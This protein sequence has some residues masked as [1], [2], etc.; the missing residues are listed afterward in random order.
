MGG[1][2]SIFI[3]HTPGDVKFNQDLMESVVGDWYVEVKGKEHHFRVNYANAF[4][5]P[6]G[7]LMNV[8]LTE[9]SQH[10]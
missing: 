1:E 2:V 9:D 4:D 6:V 10:Y 5:K 3:S 8:L 7:G